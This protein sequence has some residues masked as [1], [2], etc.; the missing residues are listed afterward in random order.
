MNIIPRDLVATIKWEE[1]RHDYDY[2][3]FQLGEGQEQFY[4]VN[5]HWPEVFINTIDQTYST[6]KCVLWTH[7]KEW[8]VKQFNKD[9][10]PASGWEVKEVTMPIQTW[11]VNPDVDPSVVFANDPINKYQIER[12]DVEYQHVW[13]LDPMYNFCDDRVWVYKSQTEWSNNNTKDMGIVTPD[14]EYEFNPELPVLH[15][16]L[17]TIPLYDL[18]YEHVW[19][20]DTD[21]NAWDDMWCVKV[22]PKW[23]DTDG[24]KY[25]GMIHPEFEVKYNDE[26]PDLRLNIDYKV[27]FFDFKYE[28][29]WY[30]DPKYSGS[31]KIWLA[32]MC[33]VDAPTGVKDMGYVIPDIAE[34]LDVIFISYN[35]PNAEENWQRVLSKAPKAKRV[36]KVK[37]IFEAHK[38]AA[39]LAAS[40][41]FYV[42]DGDAFLTDDWQFD[43]NPNIFDRDCVHVYKSK[44]PINSLTYGY[45]GVKLFPRK[46]LIDATEWKVDMTTSIA[47]KLKVINKVSNITAFNT[48]EFST[49]RSAFREC[50][51]LASAIINNQKDAETE[52]RLQIWLTKGANKPFGKFAITGANAG[53]A[54]GSANKLN[55]DLMKLINDRDWLLEQYNGQI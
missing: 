33:A 14:V 48:D 38:A 17:D 7:G 29:V 54:Y 37:G 8:I 1:H 42:V 45:G 15:L 46:L 30:L 49:W 26:I 32:T 9:W 24:V 44:N 55:T 28:H 34:Q 2:A 20:L 31:K 25:R 39:E 22:R 27:P 41:M 4:I 19:D 50:A 23:R 18:R 12:W 3:L 43:F 16:Q 5:P 35:E 6:D 52:R 21:Y 36:D 13:Y 10:T 47:S 53:Y 51:K 11:E 40:D